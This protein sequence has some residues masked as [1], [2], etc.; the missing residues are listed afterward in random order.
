MDSSCYF[1][2]LKIPTCFLNL[3]KYILQSAREIPPSANFRKGL[4]IT[5]DLILCKAYRGKNLPKFFHLNHL[6]YN[7]LKDLCAKFLN[8]LKKDMK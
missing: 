7:Y 4:G 3:Q 5:A 8:I 2:D 6:Q 1:Q